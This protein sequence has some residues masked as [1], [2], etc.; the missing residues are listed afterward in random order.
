MQLESTNH[1]AAVHEIQ[2]PMLVESSP[3]GSLHLLPNP[4]DD[5][6]WPPLPFHDGAVF[7]TLDAV[8]PRDFGLQDRGASHR[9]AEVWEP[10][11]LHDLFPL[12]GELK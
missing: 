11:V 12:Y 3:L 7:E 4:E 2:L 5:D 8:L 9:T 6:P 1:L 10:L